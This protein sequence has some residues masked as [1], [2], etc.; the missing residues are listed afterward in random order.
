MQK[1]EYQQNTITRADPHGAKVL[2]K[3]MHSLKSQERKLDE[4][5]LTEVPDVEESIS[6]SFEEVEI[7]RAKNIKSGLCFD[8][9]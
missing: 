8:C 2:K 7:P 6:F 9:Y 5:E 3:K 4:T 1:V